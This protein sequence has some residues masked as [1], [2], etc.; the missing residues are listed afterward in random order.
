ML[1]ENK[2]CHQFLEQI[3]IGENISFE[4]CLKKAATAQQ[5]SSSKLF[6]WGNGPIFNNKKTGYCACYTDEQK[7]I[8]NFHSEDN[9][10][11][12]QFQHFEESTDNCWKNENHVINA[13]DGKTETR[14]EPESLHYG[15]CAITVIGMLL[16]YSE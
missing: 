15:I 10:H 6:E 13:I 11:M 5:C 12:V 8:E 9:E 14:V 7:C 3:E 16:N 1:A 2:D 4:E